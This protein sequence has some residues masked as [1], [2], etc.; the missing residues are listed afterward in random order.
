MVSSYRPAVPIIGCS[1]SEKTCN[2]LAL[3]WGVCPV[4]AQ[5][6]E[7]TDMQFE[8]AVERARPSGW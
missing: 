2:Q 5:E 4:L 8:H 1:P 3:S 6:Q 7:N